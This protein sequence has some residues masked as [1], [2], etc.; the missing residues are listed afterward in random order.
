MI[1]RHL[2][3]QELTLA[4]IDDVIARGKRKDWE[5]LRLAVL[6]NPAF[7]K[8]VQQVCRR[9]IAD[10]YAQRYHFWMHYAEEHLA[11]VKS[12]PQKTAKDK[13]V[14]RYAAKLLFQFRV[15]VD[16]S[17]RIR[18]LCEERIVTFPATYGRAA[19]REAK[20]LGHAAQHHYKNT[21]GN[22]VHFEFVGVMELLRLKPACD[23]DE[24]W[25]EITQRVRPME[26]RAFIIQRESQLSAIRNEE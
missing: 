21:Y 20:R 3:H 9:R 7:L 14:G 23:G 15:T 26:R 5:E 24:V 12:S 2:N 17:S 19:L 1:H 22:P 25:Y 6:G 13:L 10:P 18:R 11:A 16:G 8:K 4:A